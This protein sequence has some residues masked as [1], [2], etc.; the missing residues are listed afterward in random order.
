MTF[1]DIL[2][3]TVT[4]QF[5]GADG[6]NA[7]S[8]RVAFR[9]S[10]LIVTPPSTPSSIQAT[11]TITSIPTS[12]A[13]IAASN[14]GS[15]PIGAT[16]GV[17]IGVGAAVLLLGV[18]GLAW[19]RYRKRKQAVNVEEKIHQPLPNPDTSQVRVDLSSATVSEMDGAPGL[20]EL[21]TRAKYKM[22]WNH[23][24]SNS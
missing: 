14:S 5:S 23:N 2:G 3:N 16:V 22:D 13:D 15:F 24:R 7:H 6:I 10:D 9:S 18:A 8:I 19:R 1:T 12:D 20:Y 11:L 21:D 4:T 17:G